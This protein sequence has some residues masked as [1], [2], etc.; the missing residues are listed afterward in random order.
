LDAFACA[1]EAKRAF[2]GAKMGKVLLA[3]MRWFCA[4]AC[5]CGVIACK[6][7]AVTARKSGTT[8]PFVVDVLPVRGQ[9]FRQTLSATGSLLAREAVQLQSERAGVVKEIFFEEGQLAKAGD[10]LLSIDDADLQAQLA[11]AKAQLDFATSVEARQRNLLE[12]RGISAA[13]F[14]QSRANLDIAKAE[15]KLI[16]TQVAKTKLR[17]PF[18][19]IAGLRNVSIGAYLTPGTAICT[20][21]DIGSL[22]IDFSLPE[23][24]LGLIKPGQVVR[25]RVS[26]RAERFAAKIAAIEPAVDV[27]TRSITVRATVPNEN[28]KLLP[29]SFAEVEVVLDEVSDAILIPS[30]ALMPGLQQQTVFV[31][32]AGL[33]VARKVQVGLR[34]S[35]AVQI[36]EGL[37]FGDQL[38]TSGILQLRPGMRVE[39]KTAKDK[40]ADAPAP[41][42]TEST[43]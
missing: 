1:G 27:P 3:I 6:R 42:P 30:I 38:I 23:R 5:C 28:T 22:K 13:D 8:A 11:R 33:V 12:S 29:G 41:A 24:Y 9:P 20:F 39:V 18:D 10:V 15:V 31:H 35:D 40:V 17:A 34:T 32:E 25:F 21:Q 43:P 4:A 37:K 14:D 7:G 36:L 19:G 2:F 16:E 26:G